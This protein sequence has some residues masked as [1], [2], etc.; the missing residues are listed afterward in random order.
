MFVLFVV[1][2]SWQKYIVYI[3]AMFSF[4]V[5]HVEGARGKTN[6]YAL[7]LPLLGKHRA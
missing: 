6:L 1:R 5:V 7:G 4:V 3:T 2:R